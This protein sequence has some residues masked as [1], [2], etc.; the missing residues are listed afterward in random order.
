[1]RSLVRNWQTRKVK[2][3]KIISKSMN[4]RKNDDV[5]S[6]KYNEPGK[7]LYSFFP[8]S[9]PVTKQSYL[10]FVFF[11]LI[12][13][14][15]NFKWPWYKNHMQR[16]VISTILSHIYPISYNLVSCQSVRQQ[17]TFENHTLISQVFVTWD[18][19]CFIKGM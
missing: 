17:T 7:S 14:R 3:W 8:C 19:N 18:L 13:T 15:P 4:I 1:M 16:P 12:E 9:F 2:K 5:N 10:R 11:C 6:S